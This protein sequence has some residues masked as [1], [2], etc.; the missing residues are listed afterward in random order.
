MRQAPAAPG[1]GLSRHRRSIS[2]TPN[3]TSEGSDTWRGRKPSSSRNGH[4]T[5]VPNAL[6][7]DGTLSF[8]EKVIWVI[9]RSYDWYGTGCY[10]SVTTLAA[11]CG[12]SERQVLTIVHRLEARGLV[13]VERKPGRKNTYHLADLSV[14]SAGDVSDDR[15]VN[16]PSRVNGTSPAKRTS[17]HQKGSGVLK[18]RRQAQPGRG[19]S[20]APVKPASHEEDL[21]EEHSFMKTQKG[22]RKGSLRS[23][24]KRGGTHLKL[25]SPRY[26]IPWIASYFVDRLQEQDYYTRS[27][28]PEDDLRA[29]TLDLKNNA[30]M[31]RQIPDRVAAVTAIDEW[32]A[33]G[34]HVKYDSRL[35]WNSFRGSDA[36]NKHWQWK[37]GLLIRSQ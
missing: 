4:Y 9:L 5:T 30:F 27:L 37:R 22:I 11:G 15:Y 2:K 14:G 29:V 36:R 35:G 19:S 1:E 34:E 24:G 21:D 7:R 26:S 23:T 3:T 32:I 16:I 8:G 25:D 12:R 31:C 10:P 33:S 13:T 20:R 28:S 18:A 6:I 17:R